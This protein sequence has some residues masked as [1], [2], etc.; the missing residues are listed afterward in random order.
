MVPRFFGDVVGLSEEREGPA[1]VALVL[2][3]GAQVVQGDAHTDQIADLAP[4]TE[5]LLE[6]VERLLELPRVLEHEAEVVE[7]QR[8]GPAVA[9]LAA[10]RQRALR[11]LEGARIIAS[12]PV[13]L[14]DVV[15]RARDA[16]L[17]H[18]L[19]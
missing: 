12:Q 15:H 2:S 9:D 8:D 16:A 6:A 4:D 3:D 13:E 17:V 10:R 18:R 1:V 7:R 19:L 14:A 11:E 5:R